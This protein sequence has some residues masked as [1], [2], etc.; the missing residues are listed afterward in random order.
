MLFFF[1]FPQSVVCKIIWVIFLRENFTGDRL[2]GLLVDVL[3]KVAH[4]G[5]LIHVMFVC[6]WKRTTT[7][8][9]VTAWIS[10]AGIPPTRICLSRRPE[11]KPSASGMYAPPNASPPS[12]RRVGSWFLWRTESAASTD[13]RLLLFA[14]IFSLGVIVADRSWLIQVTDW[15][16]LWPHLYIYVSLLTL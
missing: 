1:S 12:T 15:D 13:L 2:A 5:C 11:T 6:R 8:V 9:T 4:D 14:C 3:C 16:P 10:S 7:E